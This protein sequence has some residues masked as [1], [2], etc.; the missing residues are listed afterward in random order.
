VF[1]GRQAMG[2]DKDG[3]PN[4]KTLH[5]LDNF[6]FCFYI[7]GACRLIEDEHYSTGFESSNS[8]IE[9]AMSSP[10]MHQSASIAFRSA[11]FGVALML[12]WSKVPPQSNSLAAPD[13]SEG[14]AKRK[15]DLILLPIFTFSLVCEFDAVYTRFDSQTTMLAHTYNTYRLNLTYVYDYISFPRLCLLLESRFSHRE[16]SFM[17]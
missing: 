11:S 10:T 5:H 6:S 8:A 1:Q 9:S 2:D 12:Y 16:S 14:D 4:A 3:A 7:D 15:S 13:A 17:N